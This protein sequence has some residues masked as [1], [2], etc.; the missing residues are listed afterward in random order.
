MPRN[1]G[2][3]I[4]ALVAASAI[5]WLLF[6]GGSTRPRSH[7]SCFSTRDCDKGQWCVVEPK[8]DG[9]ATAG[10]CGELCQNEAACP[11]GW[12]CVRSFET[13]DGTL[14]PAGVRGAGGEPRQVC[15]PR[16]KGL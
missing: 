13:Q 5:A 4:A 2:L 16:P 9:F 7:G 14:V 8:G 15:T 3:I 12:R 10:V 1:A 6:G 11:N